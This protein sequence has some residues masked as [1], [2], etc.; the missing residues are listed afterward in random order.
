MSPRQERTDTRELIQEFLQQT[1]SLS[2]EEVAG[3]VGVSTTAVKRWRIIPP[4]QLPREQRDRLLRFV[5][6]EGSRAAG[7]AESECPRTGD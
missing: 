5:G 1:G 6:R 3:I 7:P 2:C 4:G